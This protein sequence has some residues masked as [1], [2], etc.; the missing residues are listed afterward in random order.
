MNI[1]TKVSVFIIPVLLGGIAFPIGIW[2]TNSFSGIN[3]GW[4]FVIESVIYYGVGLSLSV[5]FWFKKQHSNLWF[6]IAGLLGGTILC[7][8]VINLIFAL[9]CY[10]GGGCI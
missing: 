6:L 4:V 5:L 3:I 7:Y 8:L 9:A 10:T 1:S 2:L